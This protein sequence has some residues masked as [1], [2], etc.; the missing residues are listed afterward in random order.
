LIG[1][2]FCGGRAAETRSTPKSKV[3]RTQIYK[4]KTESKTSEHEE[5]KH[6]KHQSQIM[7]S[8]EQI[9]NWQT[10]KFVLKKKKLPG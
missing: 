3:E 5:K 4:T 9:G 1:F 7:C 10:L 2:I 6:Q 8:R